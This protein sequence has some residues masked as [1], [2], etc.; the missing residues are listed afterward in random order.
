MSDDG[1]FIAISDSHNHR[2]QIFRNDGSFVASYGSR[3]SGDGQFFY[4]SHL[5]LNNEGDLLVCDN[6]NHRIVRIRAI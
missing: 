4:P 5:C 2:V 6:S 1:Q 3:G